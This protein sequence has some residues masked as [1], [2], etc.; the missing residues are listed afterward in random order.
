MRG[1]S[2]SLIIAVELFQQY[3]SGESVIITRNSIKNIH[4]WK[5]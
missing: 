3:F 4:G 5:N 1:V 2:V